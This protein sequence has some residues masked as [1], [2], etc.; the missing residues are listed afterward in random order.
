VTLSA[1]S[2]CEIIDLHDRTGHVDY[3]TVGAGSYL[4]FESASSRPSPMPKS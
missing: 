3:V 1:E 4:E 2:L